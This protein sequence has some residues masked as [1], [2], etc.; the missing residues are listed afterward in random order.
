MSEV[1]SQVIA[2]FDVNPWLVSIIRVDFAVDIAGYSVEWFRRHARVSHKQF[3]SEYGSFRSEGKE[4]ETLYFGKRP[5]CFRVY[6][7]QR[8]IRRRYG[9]KVD[10]EATHPLD[11]HGDEKIVTRVERQY[12]GGRIPSKITNLQKL[13]A[14]CS[15]LNP[16]EPMRFLPITITDQCLHGLTGD[17]FIKGHGVLR[18][19]EQHGFHRAKQIIDEKSC[20]NTNRILSRVTA[21]LPSDNAS[22][23]PDLWTVYREG[24]RNQVR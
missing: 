13:R 12:G 16:F 5:N 2:V 24:I 10:G 4:V 6:D 20:R 18:L 23:P 3:S 1:A 21:L 11:R 8:A 15:G 14:N 17:D 19:I 22:V 9:R 7:K